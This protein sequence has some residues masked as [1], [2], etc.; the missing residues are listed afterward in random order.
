MR[1]LSRRPRGSTSASPRT[2]PSL[3]APDAGLRAR[4]RPLRRLLVAAAAGGARSAAARRRQHPSVASPAASRPVPVRLGREGE[5]PRAGLTVH[6]MDEPFDTGP[7]LAQ[8]SRPMPADTS[9]EGLI[10]TLAG[11]ERRARADGTAPRAVRRP[12]RSADRRRRDLRRP[13]RRSTTPSSTRP[14]PAP[15]S[16]PGAGLA[17]DVRTAPSSGRSRPST[18][19]ACVSS[20]LT[21]RRS[22]RR[23]RCRGSRPSDGPLWL[24]SVEPLD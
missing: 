7:I 18:G 20:T 19:V 5:R 21:A 2:R 3:L 15:S 13:L 10:P 6:L 1:L 17:A 8:G 11:A 9:L 4:A 16:S 12:R 24:T 23:R 14:A 22:R